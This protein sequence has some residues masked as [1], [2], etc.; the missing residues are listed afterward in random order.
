MEAPAL[1]QDFVSPVED[2]LKLRQLV[3]LLDRVV[4]R[5]LQTLSATSEQLYCWLKSFYSIDYF[6]QPFGLL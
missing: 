1:L 5:C 2:E 3:A 6:P 4:D